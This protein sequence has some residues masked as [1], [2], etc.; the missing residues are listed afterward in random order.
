MSNPIG[1]K[2]AREAKYHS[3][4]DGPTAFRHDCSAWRFVDEDAGAGSA[5]QVRRFI[6][7]LLR[8]IARL[9]GC[10]SKPIYRDVSSLHR[11]L[12][13]L[14]SLASDVGAM[15]GNGRISLCQHRQ[16]AYQPL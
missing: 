3:H 1:G 9:C 11:R 14:S 15:A 10:E 7:E 5:R 8:N 12:Q 13:Q 16:N 4:Y 6:L 2:D